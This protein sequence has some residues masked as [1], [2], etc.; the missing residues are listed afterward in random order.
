M[1]ETDR[2]HI[3]RVPGRRRARLTAAPGST[4]EPVPAD[5]RAGEQADAAASAPSSERGP[6][7]DRL[8]LDKPP[9][10]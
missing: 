3:E 6:N 1:S 8:R 2:Q 10:Y 4:T 5:E 9:H 7:D